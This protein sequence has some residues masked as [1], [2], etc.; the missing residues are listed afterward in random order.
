MSVDDLFNAILSNKRYKNI[1]KKL[2]DEYIETGAPVGS[3][4]L[5]KR[6]NNSLSPATIRNV[7]AELERLGVLCS[8]HTSSGRKPTEKGWRYFVNTFIEVSED[9]QNRFINEINLTKG[10]K[11]TSSLLEKT[12]EVLSQ[13]SNCASIIVAPTFN[14]K[15]IEYIDFVMLS[16]GKGLAIIV[17]EDGSIENRLINITKNIS[18]GSLQRAAKYLNT[19]LCGHSLSEITE[20]INNEFTT[21]KNGLDKTTNDIIMQ[22][23]G[24]WSDREDD[25][26][27]LIVKGHSN[28]LSNV[29]EIEN[30]KMLFNKLD[31]KH[32]VK[33]LLNEAIN[34]QGIQV[35]IGS[36]NK[37]F[38]LTGC[39]MII[40]PYTNSKNKV[41]GAIGVIGPE[42]M[43]YNKVIN[44]V[45]L[46]AKMLSKLI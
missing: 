13:L 40:S 38:N 21:D 33:I 41:I 1:F 27:K 26:S 12:S 44:L 30:I 17:L 35:F 34:S 28:L 3:K 23:I 4:T 16:E 5:S 32:T 43:K 2:V 45:D 42:R 14:D 6:M 11:N 19:K 39:S 20:T 24:M 10:A 31:E 22:G 29:D 7:M 8:E 36:E 9:I 37:A 15:T 46:T 25:N 18:T